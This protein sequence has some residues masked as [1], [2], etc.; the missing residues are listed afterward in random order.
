MLEISCSNF[1][2]DMDIGMVVI[3]QMFL[4]LTQGEKS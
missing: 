4:L 3:E 2:C 1:I